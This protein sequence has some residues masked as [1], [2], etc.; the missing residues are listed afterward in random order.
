MKRQ[1]MTQ[2]LS[3]IALLTIIKN[4]SF[5]VE[6]DTG[7]KLT[8]CAFIQANLPLLIVMAVCVL[9]IILAIC[10]LISFNVFKY[11]D[12][13]GAFSIAILEEKDEDSLNFF[14]TLVLPLLID[15]VNTWQGVTLF[16]VILILTWGLMANTR[17]FYANPILSFLGY[18]ITEIEFL[19]N[20]EKIK[21]SYIAIS[22]G[23][24]DVKHNVEYKDITEDVLFVKGM[25][26]NECNRNADCN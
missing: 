4:F 26:D 18:R 19:A 15:N 20:P 5:V 23:A 14:L 8:K 22:R 25:K 10:F 1:L 7:Q 17:L 9:W 13:K 2:S 11:A 12:K 24:L 16:F 21:A 3:P 6:S